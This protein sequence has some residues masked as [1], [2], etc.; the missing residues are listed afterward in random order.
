MI[1]HSFFSIQKEGMYSNEIKKYAEK[2]DI[3]DKVI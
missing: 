3:V 2:N 1:F